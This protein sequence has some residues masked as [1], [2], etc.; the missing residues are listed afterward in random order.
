[1]TTVG[2]LAS[3]PVAYFS[4]GSSGSSG[5]GEIRGDAGVQGRARLQ[6]RQQRCE[7]VSPE[8]SARYATAD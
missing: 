5:G 2:H 7:P 4:S 1:M 8:R 6:L 3:P